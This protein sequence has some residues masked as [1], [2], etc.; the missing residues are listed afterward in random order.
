MVDMVHLVNM[1]P[2]HLMFISEHIV[3]FSELSSFCHNNIMYSLIRDKKRRKTWGVWSDL[4]H[5]FR[6][7]FLN[8]DMMDEDNDNNKDIS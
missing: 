2:Q 1:R 3:F 5:S 4:L 6:P 7:S 8:M